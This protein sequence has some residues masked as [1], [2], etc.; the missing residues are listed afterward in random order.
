MIVLVHI[1]FGEIRHSAATRQA[2][3]HA[4]VQDGLNKVWA[5][6]DK[7]PVETQQNLQPFRN[8]MSGEVCSFIAKVRAAKTNPL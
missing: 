7:L 5:N 2:A 3:L 4:A 1:I 8:A 6:A